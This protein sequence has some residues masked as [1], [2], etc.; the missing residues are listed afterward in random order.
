ME[1]LLKSCL[2]LSVLRHSGNIP[3]IMDL[4]GICFSR[5]M[6]I[7][8][9]ILSS[10]MGLKLLK[11]LMMHST[12]LGSISL[13]NIA[14]GEGDI[15]KLVKDILDFGILLANLFQIVHKCLFIV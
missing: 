13:K 4:L 6:R 2:N 14:L 3:L 15:T 12:C 10:P 8:F 9:E 1:N 5:A 11:S 7:L